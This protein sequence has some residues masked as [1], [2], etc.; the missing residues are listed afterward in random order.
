VRLRGSCVPEFHPIARGAG[1]LRT[2]PEFVDPLGPDGIAGTLDDDLRLAVGSPCIDRANDAFLPHLATVDLA[3]RP[4][5][6][7]ALDCGEGGVLD[8]GAY[9]NQIPA[10]TTNH[11][12][13]AP[14][15]LGVP[16]ALAGPCAL[17]LDAGDPTFVASP[18]P[19]GRG[20]LYF[21][22]ERGET[23][24]GDGLLCVG[25]TLHRT[26]AALVVNGVLS[27]DVDVD[28][29]ATAAALLPGTSWSFQALYRDPNAGGTG[30]NLSDAVRVTFR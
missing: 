24:F 29:P 8:I 2:D 15:S 11:C 26:P 3:G 19:T 18:V 28:S 20:F 27:V 9:E 14:S 5:A 16:A 6:F 10:G 13:A 1:N 7:D 4:R 23:P 12:V 22:P 17:D 30:F 21:G 25:G